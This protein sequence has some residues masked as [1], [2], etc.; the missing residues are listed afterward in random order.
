MDLYLS[1]EEHTTT[2]LLLTAFEPFNGEGVNPSLVAWQ[3]L[4]R[5]PLDGVALVDGA[6][7]A[8]AELPVDCF[9]A[10][11][12]ALH[13]VSGNQNVRYRRDG[14]RSWADPR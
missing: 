6:A 8:V 11:D 9:Q 12:M 5:T 2:T 13:C 7:L 3:A 10:V 14:G 4:E 1:Q